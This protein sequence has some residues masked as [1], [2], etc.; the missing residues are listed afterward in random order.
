MSEWRRYFICNQWETHC[1]A[2]ELNSRFEHFTGIIKSH[3]LQIIVIKLLYVLF[4]NYHFIY[5]DMLLSNYNICFTSLLNWAANMPGAVTFIDQLMAHLGLLLLWSH[6]RTVASE[7]WF[8]H[9]FLYN[10]NSLGKWFSSSHKVSRPLDQVRNILTTR[11]II[12][13]DL[14]LLDYVKW[15]YF[16]SMLL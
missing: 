13:F 2:S 6:F 1:I 8:S 4:S 3:Y 9:T 10:S 12:V 15:D 11:I 16:Y 7:D 5:T 14:E